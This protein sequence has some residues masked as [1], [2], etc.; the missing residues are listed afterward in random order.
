MSD[1]RPTWARRMT[2]EREARGWTQADAVTA[3]RM[4][5]GEQ[6]QNLPDSASML[7]QWKRWESG[8]HAPGDFYKPVIAAVFGTAT[9]ALFPEPGRRDGNAEILAASGMD[10][11]ELV[12]RMQASD[13]DTAVI[14]AMRIT[15]DQLCSDY[16]FVP[17]EQLLAEGRGWLRRLTN[18]RGQ[19]QTLSQHRETLVLAG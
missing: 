19:R 17:G 18:L 15:T 14:D 5:A 11:L 7:R 6:H 2:R 12:S 13:L 10:T 16:P 3:M 4:H 9:Y 8:E 1:D